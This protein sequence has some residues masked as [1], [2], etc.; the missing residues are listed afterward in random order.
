M[1]PDDARSTTHCRGHGP[2]AQSL[3]RLRG[4]LMI[5]LSLALCGIGALAWQGYALHRANVDLHQQMR[6]VRADQPGADR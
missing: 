3:D 2:L 4:S 5:L 1:T 6:T